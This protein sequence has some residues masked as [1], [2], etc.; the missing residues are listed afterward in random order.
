M[1]QPSPNELA[2]AAAHIRAGRNKEAQGLLINFVRQYPGDENG[3]LLLSL[4]V[5]EPKQQ[6]DCLQRVLRINPGNTEAR[7]RLTK[8]LAPPPPPEI[9]PSQ[10]V[11]PPFAVEAVKEIRPE[12][13]AAKAP[14]P[15]PFQAP[16]PEPDT[17][18]TGR[19]EQ[20]EWTEWRPEREIPIGRAEPSASKPAPHV[21]TAVPPPANTTPRPFKPKPVP[22]QRT[23]GPTDQQIINWVLTGG[24]IFIVLLIIGG[25]TY[26]G[27]VMYQRSQ[28]SQAAATYQV[29]VAAASAVYP[30]LPP[31]WTPTFTPTI[32]L[33]PTITPTS[34]STPVPTPQAPPEEILSKMDIIQQ[35]VADLRG[36]AINT[37]NVQE[38]LIDQDQVRATLEELYLTSGGSHEEV[39]EEAYVLSALGLIK[40]TFD[41]FTYS[42]NGISDGLGGFYIPWSQKLYVIG[43][44][45]SGVEKYIYSHEYNHALTDAHFKIRDMGVYPV[46]Q[47]DQ[48]RCTAIRALVEG[49]STIL[50]NQ[51]FTQYAGPQDIKDLLT[52]DY[53][54]SNQT[55]PQQF[56]PPFVSRDGAFPYV[57][58]SYFVEALYNRGNW[59]EVNKAY[60]NLPQSTEQIL[61]PQK[62]L[63]GEV[64]VVVQLPAL[65]GAVGG[66]WRE[67]ATNTLGEW[68]TFLV[69]SYGADIPAQLSDSQ[70]EEAAAGWGGDSYRVLRNDGSG[71][72]ILIIQ[73]V[74]DTDQDASEFRQAMVTYQDERFRGG[75]VDRSDGD[76]W[77]ANNQASCTFTRANQTLWIIAPNQTMLNDI[78]AKFAAFQ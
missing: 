12:P 32:T 49:D 51:W 30:T 59:A 22:A 14:P 7:V 13:P 78:R 57:E 66:E 6:I 46:C 58:G 39:N 17:F 5:N 53:N 15:T 38:Y 2:Q 26:G 35:Q 61:H 73:W 25:G 16:E 11:V 36:L 74:W 54:P 48:Q 27:L 18:T 24:I 76:C 63:A 33:T 23:G 75:K 56:P 19:N 21:R 44:R 42:L 34:T 47:G 62:Y 29:A 60:Q 4:A 45:F 20:S 1:T 72:L 68:E 31:T 64:P 28:A 43:A 52:Y 55:L 10:V 3:W 50:M 9:Y 77:E 67:V 65:E 71:E 69:L 70:G 41:L 37:D 40:P 8:L